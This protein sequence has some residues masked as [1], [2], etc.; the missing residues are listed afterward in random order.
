MLVNIRQTNKS[1][2]LDNIKSINVPGVDSSFQILN[3]HGNLVSLLKKGKL[4]YK[5]EE[6]IEN[7]IDIERGGIIYVANNNVKIILV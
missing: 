4:I 6:D 2:D 7:S 1:I 5:N 3:N